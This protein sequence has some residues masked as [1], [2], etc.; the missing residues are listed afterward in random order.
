MPAYIATVF[1]A[2]M[3]AL[4]LSGRCRERRAVK[5]RFLAV[6]T[7][8]SHLGRRAGG[9]GRR[10]LAVALVVVL[11]SAFVGLFLSLTPNTPQGSRV[12]NDAP[13]LTL[14]P[15]LSPTLEPTATFTV[16]PTE[17]P[18]PAPVRVEPS[19]TPVPPQGPFFVPNPNGQ[20]IWATVDAGEHCPSS[21]TLIWQVTIQLDMPANGSISWHWV[22]Y[23]GDTL[24]QPAD[25]VFTGVYPTPEDPWLNPQGGVNPVRLSASDSWVISGAD[26]TGSKARWGS[27]VVIDTVNGMPLSTPIASAVLHLATGC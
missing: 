25:V 23:D 6:W 26:M 1:W 3:G 16:I 8:A 9:P 13:T 11:V 20:L 14:S 18:S 4:L 5:T 21:A 12:A 27:Q 10:I 22:R 2:L 7:H 15:T 17:T 24:G 19:A